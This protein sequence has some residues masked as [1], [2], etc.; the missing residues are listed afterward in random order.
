[1]LRFVDYLTKLLPSLCPATKVAAERPSARK[2]AFADSEKFAK[3]DVGRRSRLRAAT[4]V[5]GC[6]G[7]NLSYSVDFGHAALANFDTQ[8]KGVVVFI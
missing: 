7:S 5:A 4:L 6:E 8:K 1:M 2:S 3:A